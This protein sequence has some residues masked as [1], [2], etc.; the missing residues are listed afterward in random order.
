MRVKIIVSDPWDLGESIHWQPLGGELIRVSKGAVAGH[1]LIKLDA[2]ID[3]GDVQWQFVIGTPRHSGDRFE[4]LG[5]GLKVAGA[6]R[7]LTLQQAALEN[8]FDAVG[9][10]GGLAFIAEIE[11]H[12]T[13]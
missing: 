13:A 7:G 12:K 9:W 5:P 4:S 3:Y 6:F 10:R 8:P 1:A 11:A 2:P